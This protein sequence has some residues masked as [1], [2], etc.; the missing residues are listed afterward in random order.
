M[1]G[2][3]DSGPPVGTSRH[4]RCSLYGALSDVR[5]TLS[6]ES[7]TATMMRGG[8][9]EATWCKPVQDESGASKGRPRGTDVWRRRVEFAIRLHAAPDLN[10]LTIAAICSF[11]FCTPGGCSFSGV[12]LMYVSSSLSA[13][14]R[15]TAAI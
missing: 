14:L 10:S 12:N 1:D 11:I 8:I 4:S 3:S 2:T 13:F 9:D 15:A 7:S 6:A 5:A